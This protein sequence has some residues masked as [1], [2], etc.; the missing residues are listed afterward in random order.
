M[1]FQN[2]T[3]LFLILFVAISAI[4]QDTSILW[5]RTIGGSGIEERPQILETND[6]GLLIGGT[7]N[8]NISG[9]KTENSRGERDFWVLKLDENGV[10][11]WQRTIGGSGDENLTTLLL[12][13]DG[14][15]IIGGTSDSPISGEKTENSRGLSDY[16]ILQLDESGNITNQKT[17]GGEDGEGLQDIVQTDDG[18]YLLFGNS[19]STISADRTIPRNG[20]RDFWVL[21]LNDDFTLDLQHSFG[22]TPGANGSSLSATTVELTN[23]GAYLMCG[24]YNPGSTGDCYFCVKSTPT[25][26]IIWEKYY[27]G[28][29]TDLMRNITPTTDG[30]FIIAGTSESNISGDKEED[31]LGSFDY[32]I[33]KIDN[34][35]GNILWQN[36]IGGESIEQ[37]RTISETFDGKILICGESSSNI[38]GDKTE[39]SKGN[40][41]YWILILNEFGIIEWQNT[42]GAFERDYRNFAIELSN[43]NIVISGQSESEASAD[44]TENSRGEFDFWILTL[45]STLGLQASEL[46]NNVTLFPNPVKNSL[47]LSAKNI[48]L[49]GII[50]Y[51]A[52]GELMQTIEGFNENKTIDTS[53]LSTGIYYL[54]ISG[55]NKV[56]T[57]KFIKE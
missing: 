14:G 48:T 37:P 20:D 7:S 40:S 44:K 36:T 50:L 45:D 5:Q 54:Q 25:G 35:D 19:L 38:S 2:C 31:S 15:Y 18:G 23:D 42:I 53:S 51:S 4:S 56:I 30:N 29:L 10:I 22:G 26:I 39:N 28:D 27:C 12:L 55:E 17:Y 21:K 9:E 24:S 1:R 49:D 46:F 6:G 34:S 13:N 33:L 11:E 8:S 3:A 41:D 47:T 32:W 52:K 16:W 43:G 57:K